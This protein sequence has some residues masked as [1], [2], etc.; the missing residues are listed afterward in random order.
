LQVLDVSQNQLQHQSF[1][2]LCGVIFALDHLDTLI[3]NDTNLG[4]DE[5]KEMALAL[6]KSNLKSLYLNKNRIG[7][8]GIAALSE[9]FSSLSCSIR[10]I[11]LAGNRIGDSGIR[12]FSN[13]LFTNNSLRI[14][15][16]ASNEISDEGV[17]AFPFSFLFLIQF[18][19]LWPWAYC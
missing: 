1:S 11:H 7:D 12:D 4:D 2:K 3:L 18:P 9:P 13:S 8:S 15:D 5:V 14:L 6:A 17:S 19:R 16:V 10:E